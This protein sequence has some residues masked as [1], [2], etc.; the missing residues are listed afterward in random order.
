MNVLMNRCCR[1]ARGVL[2]GLGLL[3]G[4][5]AVGMMGYHCFEHMFW[6][7]AFVNGLAFTATLGFVFVPVVHR[8]MHRFHIGS[9]AETG[10]GQRDNQE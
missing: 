4:S 5:L 3:I 1:F 10:S 2:V 7:D 9:P 6:L 8:L